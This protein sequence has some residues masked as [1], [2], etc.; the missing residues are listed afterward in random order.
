MKGYFKKSLLNLLSFLVVMGYF[1][2]GN[3]LIAYANDWKQA[4]DPWKWVFPRDHGSHPEF[5]TEWWYFTGNL[6]D[7]SK[8][9]FGYQLTFFRQGVLYEAKD[10]NHPWAIRDVYLAHF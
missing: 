2:Y 4:I 9:G 10:P 8:K 3:I 6:A 1:G 7:S 5:R